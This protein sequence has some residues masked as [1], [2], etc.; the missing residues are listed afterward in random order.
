MCLYI[1]KN[2]KNKYKN[3][4]FFL[5]TD[6][7]ENH[8]KPQFFYSCFTTVSDMLHIFFEYFDNQMS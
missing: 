5:Y 3:I 7:D 6:G 8:H 1:E 4:F 2:K